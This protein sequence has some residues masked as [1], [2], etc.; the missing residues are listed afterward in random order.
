MDSKFDAAIHAL[1]S[2]LGWSYSS[3][4]IADLRE[5]LKAEEFFIDES[6]EIVSPSG[7]SLGSAVGR[8]WEEGPPP[9]A[10]PGAPFAATGEPTI[11]GMSKA[12]FES[13]SPQRQAELK[14]GAGEPPTPFWLKGR[15]A[16]VSVA[17]ITQRT[18]LSAEDYEKLPVE[19][20]LEITD[21]IKFNRGK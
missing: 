10:K 1:V 5:R 8:L 3:K 13:L 12:D 16:P 4:T 6:G 17:E 20:R 7:E 19:R 14:I 21:E 18:G 15:A 9:G 2:R 11:G